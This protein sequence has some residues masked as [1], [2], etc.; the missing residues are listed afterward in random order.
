MRL[1]IL[2]VM[3]I[4]MI[5][6]AFAEGFYRFSIS[7]DYGYATLVGGVPPWYTIE[8][9]YGLKIDTYFKNKWRIGMGINRYK[10]Y[11]DSSAHNEFKF[12]SD[13]QFRQKVWK[14]YDLVLFLNY[15][16]T[17]YSSRLSAE[18]GFGGGV[19]VWKIHDAMT[20]T[21]IKTIGE[22]GEMTDLAAT[23]VLLLSKIGVGYRLHPRFMLGIDIYANYLTGAGLE[24][25]KTFEKQLSKWNLKTSIKLSYL[26]G[27]GGW[28][29]KMT[30][31]SSQ[32]VILQR[33]SQTGKNEPQPQEV[34]I[35]AQNRA[36]ADG[37][38]IP[39]YNDD[40]PGTPGAAY[41]MVDL[42]GCPVDVDCDGVPD[43]LDKCPRNQVG[44]LVDTYG[45]PLDSDKDG[46]PD[47][48]DDCPESDSGL[49]VDNTG[50]IDLTVLEKPVILNIKYESGSFEIDRDTQEKLNQ[51]SRLLLKAPGIRVEING[52]TDN[53][54]TAEANQSLSQKRANR[55]RDYLA[56]MGIES[57]R[58][59][60]VGKG[61]VN[62]VASNETSEG[63]QKNRRVELVFFK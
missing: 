2:L 29:E 15:N 35:P 61:E 11:D 28:P 38:G 25:D 53:I 3:L 14:G 41:G 21:T 60:P 26:F 20:D 45:C 23:E 19:T 48:L 13:E 10:I 40:C 27:I 46:V 58:L 33:I 57:S 55:V 37:D 51:I 5:S 47:G 12:G 43:Y 56:K 44:A 1:L 30:S 8:N 17:P 49:A 6:P 16:L 36:D 42:R 34:T 31:G 7:A 52:Y 63:R 32:G 62:F 50:C 4:T 59:T 24:F 54:G 18:A 22:R 39:D 9:T